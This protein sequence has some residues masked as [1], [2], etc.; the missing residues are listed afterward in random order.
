MMRAN[1]P[2]LRHTHYSGDIPLGEEIRA[3]KRWW[4]ILLLQLTIAKK[5]TACRFYRDPLRVQITS[6]GG[7]EKFDLSTYVLVN[8]TPFSLILMP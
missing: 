7:C 1:L 5:M 3:G 4:R 6:N 8:N 2:S